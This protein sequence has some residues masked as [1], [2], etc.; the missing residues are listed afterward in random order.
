MLNHY[1]LQESFACR[2]SHCNHCEIKLNISNDEEVVC[3]LCGETF[4]DRCIHI[5]Q[6]YCREI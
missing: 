2:Y 6:I 3:A 5:H 1:A 4:C